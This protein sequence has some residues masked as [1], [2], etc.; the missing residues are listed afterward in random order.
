MCGCWKH[1]HKLRESGLSLGLRTILSFSYRHHRILYFLFS[2]P[3][4]KLLSMNGFARVKGFCGELEDWPCNQ[5][6][7]WFN[8]RASMSSANKMMNYHT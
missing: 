6:F 3:G 7:K 4:G 8:M 5:N 2:M 1:W